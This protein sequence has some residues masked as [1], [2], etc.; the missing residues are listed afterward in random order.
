MPSAN[1]QLILLA[2]GR[3]IV[4]ITGGVEVRIV[5]FPDIISIVGSVKL[6]V[7]A[8]AVVLE[9]PNEEGLVEHVIIISV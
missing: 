4:V 8:R 6:L 3:L 5:D 7:E 9:T 2:K 1:H